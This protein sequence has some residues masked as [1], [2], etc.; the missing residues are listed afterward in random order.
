MG[1]I[2]W[3]PPPGW[4]E[5]TGAHIS[6]K[7]P[8]N[9]SA[10][11]A[12][13]IGDNTYTFMD[14][15]GSPVNNLGYAFISGAMVEA[16]LDCDQSRAYII[17]Q[18]GSAYAWNYDTLPITSGTWTPVFASTATAPTGTL[19]YRYAKF[20]RI[21]NMCFITFHMKETITSAGTGYARISGL[22][23]TSASS[24][25]GQGL[26]IRECS[27]G[28]TCDTSDTVA[29]IPD[30]ST[31][32]NIQHKFGQTSSKWST[33]DTWIGFTGCYLIQ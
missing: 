12:I 21:G 29:F 15:A 26:A 33:G 20:Y 25:D 10:A 11:G 1:T 6:F 9:C 4:E 28:I 3:T 8:C 23:Y 24:L 18:G 22:P 14:T 19:K 16:V 5:Q 17:S 2:N 27:G 32:I 13:K 31:Y 7:A 30:N